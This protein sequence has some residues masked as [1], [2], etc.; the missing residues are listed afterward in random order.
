MSGALTDI[1][2]TPFYL[3]GMGGRRK[4]V[5]R[6]GTL[7]D[8]VTGEILFTWD[9]LTEQMEPAEY[10]VRLSTQ[11]GQTVTLSED[12][13]GVWLD[14]GGER[15]GLSTA[16]VFLPRFDGHP[17]ADVL[18]ALYQEV[19]VNIMPAGPLPNFFVYHTPW[20]RDAATMLLCLQ[21]TGNLS[22]V[23]PWLASL[24][25]PFDRN[26]AGHEEPDNLGQAL[27]LASLSETPLPALIQNV[28]DAVPRFVQQG[29]TG[30]YITGMTDGG[31]HPVYQTKWLK[32]GLHILGLDD[33]FVVPAEFDTYSA[34]FWMDYKDAHV[35]GPRFDA[36]M[37]ALYPYLTWAEAH[38]Y[39]D[40]P[41]AAVDVS[42]YPLSWETQASE[43]DYGG[44]KSVSPELTAHRCAAPHTWHAA[45]MFLYFLHLRE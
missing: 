6:A 17:Q 16:P 29:E 39:G 40:S 20:Y 44:M 10:R 31:P 24:T 41:T 45:E 36:G 35:P 37:A 12:E 28:L 38:F 23:Q 9:V 14:K 26:N 32:F 5:Y 1:S 25:D 21:Q 43:A 4:F 13:Q 7:S 33:P 22:L 27:F 11:D 8:A 19:L 3:F 18:R 30:A 15:R 2:Y 34:L 42:R